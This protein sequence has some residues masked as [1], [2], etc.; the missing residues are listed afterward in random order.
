M[1]NNIKNNMSK[2]LEDMAIRNMSPKERLEYD[3]KKKELNM[4]LK[5]IEY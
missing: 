5:E 1:F 3:N 4:K 2:T